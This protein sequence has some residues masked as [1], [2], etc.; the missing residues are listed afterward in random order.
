MTPPPQPTDFLA[1]FQEKNVFFP[2]FQMQVLFFARYIH[3]TEMASYLRKTIKNFGEDY[4]VKFKKVLQSGMLLFDSTMQNWQIGTQILYFTKLFCIASFAAL[5]TASIFCPAP[6]SMSLQSCTHIHI[7]TGL[8]VSFW[9][10]QERKMPPFSSFSMWDR[11]EKTFSM[12][13]LG[14][15]PTPSLFIF[16]I[17]HKKSPRCMTAHNSRPPRKKKVQSCPS[18]EKNA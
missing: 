10:K 14:H 3:G 9:H 15:L 16:V 5:P 12:M 8:Q 7:C 1:Y 18:G 11:G 4:I 6:K 13:K 17:C 2:Y